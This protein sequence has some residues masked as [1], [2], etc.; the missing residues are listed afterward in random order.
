MSNHYKSWEALKVG[1]SVDIVAPAS[2]C[3]LQEIEQSAQFIERLGLQPHIP[4]NLVDETAM[5]ICANTDEM[6]GLHLKNAIRNKDSK[7][8]WCLRGGYG[9]ARIIPELAKLRQPRKSKLFMGFSDI[10]ALHLFLH[11]KWKWS[12]LHAPVLFQLG[13]QK[14]DEASVELLK[15]VIFGKRDKVSFHG[16]EPL[17]DP[18]RKEKSIYSHIIGGNLCVLQTSIG[19]AWQLKSDNHIVFIEEIGERGYAVDRMLTHLTQ[20]GILQSAQAIIFGDI[21]GGLEQD[22]V[23]LN[24]MV[25]RQ[26]AQDSTI[27]VL[28]CEGIGHGRVNHP[29]PMGE[30]VI[31]KLKE[32]SASLVCQTGSA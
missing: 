13:M 10:T 9:S 2:G 11:H 29:L 8:I 6:R 21:I 25:I 30:Q 26:F 31:L 15:D 17:N 16:L 18:A 27:P 28:R 7:A 3:T 20:S 19:T 12:V 23:S 5:T 32:D 22:G 14:V 4:E 24:E 1:D